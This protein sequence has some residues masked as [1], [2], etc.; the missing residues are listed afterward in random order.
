MVEPPRLPYC[1]LP[2]P[3][4]RSRLIGPELSTNAADVVES[5][6]KRDCSAFLYK[7]RVSV[8]RQTSTQ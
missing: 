4:A 5:E 3:L 1:D 8:L 6:P 7:G 2:I